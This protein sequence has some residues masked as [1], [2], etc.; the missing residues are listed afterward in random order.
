[1]KY[2]FSSPHPNHNLI[3][4]LFEISYDLPGVKKIQLPAWRPGRYELGNFAKNILNWKVLDESGSS[5]K[6]TKIK[7]DLWEIDLLN[8]GKIFISYSYYA[9]EINAGSSYVD[10]KQLYVNPVNCCVYD[11]ERMDEACEIDLVIPMD[12]KVACSLE[13]VGIHQ[14]KAG[15]FHELVDSPF[16]ASKDLLHDAFQINDITFHLWILGNSKPDWKRIKDDFRKYTQTQLNMMGGFPANQYHYFIQLLPYHFYHGVEHLKST[17]IALGPGYNL[18]EPHVYENLLGIC[19]HELFH[20]WNIKSIRPAEMMPY[21]YSKENYSR[22]GFV[23]EGVTTYYGDLF[24]L[25]SG[26]FSWEQYIKTFEERL[27]KHFDNPG[28]FNMPVSEASFDTWLDGYVPGVP[29]RKT[30][31]YD[32]GCLVAFFTD[33]LIRINSGNKFSLDNIMRELYNEYGKK[34]RGYSFN[35]YKLLVEKFAGIH[36]D[37]FFNDFVFGIK[38]YQ[39]VLE[40]CL[41][42]L[43]LELITGPSG[44]LHESLFGVK[45]MD[46]PGGFRITHIFPDGPADRAGAMIGDK[47]I[48]INSWEINANLQDLLRFYGNENISINYFRRSNLNTIEIKCSTEPVYKKY[49]V[50][51]MEGISGEIQRNFELWAGLLAQ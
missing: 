34:K 15:D 16:I 20:A 28:R 9:S 36:L 35:D 48:A 38:S 24:L 33:Y 37:D 42:Y 50:N 29:G 30:S 25:R 31:I 41:D 47:W 3:D 32:E 49:R 13:P 18:M 17:V 1:M 51:R 21:D 19:S 39:P 5:V 22:L 44:K 26:V 46:E 12:Y 4:I 2:T 8:P 23:A 45:G 27:Q 11:Q 14:F 40:S 6:S 10:D 43:G 7:K